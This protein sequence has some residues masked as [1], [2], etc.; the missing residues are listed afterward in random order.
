MRGGGRVAKTC[1]ELQEAGHWEERRLKHVCSETGADER[2]TSPIR[3][4]TP[5]DI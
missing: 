4:Q 3:N 2:M 5:T 1:A